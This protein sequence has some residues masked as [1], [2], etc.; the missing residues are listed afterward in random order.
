MIKNHCKSY[1]KVKKFKK[2]IVQGQKQDE[3]S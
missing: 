1:S 3:R 2:K